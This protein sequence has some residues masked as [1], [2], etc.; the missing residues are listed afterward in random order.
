[1]AGCCYA[2]GPRRGSLASSAPAGPARLSSGSGLR[3]K[4]KPFNRF[5]IVGT[6]RT[7]SS[8][9]AELIGLHPSIVCG[10]EWT[11]HLW[12]PRKTLLAERGLNGE[13]DWLEPHHQRHVREQ[14]SQ[15]D[16]RWLGFRRLFRSSGLWLGHP[17]WSPA[18]GVDQLGAHIRWLRRN[19]DIHVVHCRRR[20]NAEWLK[21]KVLARLNASFVGGTYDD[22]KKV[23]VDIRRALRQV[24]AKQWVD[25]ALAELAQSN[26]YCEVN[27]EDFLQDNQAEITR[28]YQFLSCA[29]IN[30]P[31][32]EAKLVKQSTKSIDEYL[33]NYHEL[34][35]QLDRRN[36]RVG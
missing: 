12:H 23:H 35:N 25:N 26:P 34:V 7:G 8:V 17:G 29:P 22:S 21:S 10:W 5:V 13:L 14:L 33:S 36:L 30:I 19:N 28:A 6:Q 27:Y 31:V 18:L 2:N 1:M 20:D 24:A 3:V 32:N 11:Q 15:K 16:C 9:I 4:T